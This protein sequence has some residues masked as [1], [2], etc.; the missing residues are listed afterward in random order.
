MKLNNKG[1]ALTS[2]I[3]MLIVLFVMVVLLI[4]ANLTSRKVV[5]DKI[6]NDVKAELDQ[7]VTIINQELPYFNIDTGIY[8]E[9]LDEAISRANNT[10]TIKDGHNV[11]IFGN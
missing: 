8:Y 10:N 9:S 1:F 4:L 2:I 7:E 6:K 3:Y 5:L 11:T